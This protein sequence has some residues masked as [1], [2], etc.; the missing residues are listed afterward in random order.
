[1]MWGL[2]SSLSLSFSLSLSL[3]SGTV[4]LVGEVVGVDGA[5]A[6]EVVGEFGG[7]AVDDSV[8]FVVVVFSL[9]AV[10]GSYWESQ[11]RNLT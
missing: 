9:S 4:G 8:V 1:V 10:V 11:L 3:P 7:S 5:G 2:S 6:G